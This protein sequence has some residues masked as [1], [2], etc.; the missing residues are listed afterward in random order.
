MTPW[1]WREPG[2]GPRWGKPGLASPRSPAWVVASVPNASAAVLCVSKRRR[3]RP[4]A[5]RLARVRR[6]HSRAADA[7]PEPARG[8]APPAQRV[9]TWIHEPAPHRRDDGHKHHRRVAG[10]QLR[11]V[12]VMA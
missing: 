12:L 8:R 11:H 3:P 9:H 1:V 5:V 10:G 7:A 2:D 4:S 6:R